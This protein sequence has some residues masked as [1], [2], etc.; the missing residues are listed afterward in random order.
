MEIDITNKKRTCSHRPQVLDFIGTPGRI[1]TADPL[2]RSQIL[3]PAELLVLWSELYTSDPRPT[4]A[5]FFSLD[6]FSP[7]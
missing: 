3:Y 5:C 7:L 6:S 4:Q 2:I 1:R